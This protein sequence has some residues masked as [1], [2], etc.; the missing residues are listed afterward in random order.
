MSLKVAVIG[1]NGKSG[2]ALVNESLKRGF[3]VTAIVRG[4]NKTKAPEAII[5]DVFALTSEDLTKFDVVFDAFGV[6]TIEEMPKHPE[7][8]KHLAQILANSNTRLLVVGGAGTL[9]LDKE[10]T[11]MLMQ[12]PDFPESY[13]PVATATG[14]ALA[15]MRKHPE[16]KWTY[17]S[18]AADF[19]ADGPATGKYTLGGEE[20][21]VN[22]KGE[23]VVSYLDFAQAMVDEAVANKHPQERVTVVADY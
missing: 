20:F 16:V 7:H 13:M 23:S 18:P 4:E 15:E 11:Q 9:F 1:A 6:W 17:F 10:H 14:E 3:A 19:R 21:I 2:Q 22:S 8:I 5:K 12:S